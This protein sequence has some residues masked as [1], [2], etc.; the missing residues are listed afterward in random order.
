MRVL[1]DP[2]GNVEDSQVLTE[3]DPS[4]QSQA[5]AAVEEWRF[6]PATASGVRVRMWINLTVV[7][8]R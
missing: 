8:Q 1:V 5:R 3:V 2:E 7:F 6:R 4:L